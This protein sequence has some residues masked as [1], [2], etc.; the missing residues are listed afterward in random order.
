[1]PVGKRAELQM[2]QVARD[3][4]S[5]MCAKALLLHI[6]PLRHRCILRMARTLLQGGW[7][8]I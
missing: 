8:S 6:G 2:H 7:A 1:M 5:R 4:T 3:P